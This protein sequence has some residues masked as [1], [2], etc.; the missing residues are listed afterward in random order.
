MLRRLGHRQHRGD[1]RVRALEHRCPLRHRPPREPLGEQPPQLRPLRLVVLAGQ[2]AWRTLRREQQL[3]EPR[4]ELRLK[5]ADRHVPA[6][7]RL[8]HVVVRCT[9]V[10]PVHPALVGPRSVCEQRERHRLQHR[11][12]VDDRGVNH[13]A[14]PGLARP[15]QRGEQAQ[16]EEH[17]PAAEVAQ[18]V[19]RDLRRAAGPPDGVQRAGDRDVADI[20]PGPRR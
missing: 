16:R 4:V 14:A 13:L 6:V 8:V 10:Q 2:G 17:R 19:D 18:I 15:Q 12:P 11:G 1:A 3:D 5:R 7:G 9:G 20:V